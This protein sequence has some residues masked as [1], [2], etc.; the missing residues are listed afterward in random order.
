MLIENSKPKFSDFWISKVGYVSADEK[1]LLQKGD[2][3]FDEYGIAGQV[4]L[5]NKD[6]G[7]YIVF[8][9]GYSTYDTDIK[10][11]KIN[12]AGKSIYNYQKSHF[13]L[14]VSLARIM[15]ET[16]SEFYPFS[17][18]FTNGDVIWV[19]GSTMDGIVD[20]YTNKNFNPNTHS[21]FS[22]KLTPKYNCE[23]ETLILKK[24]L[25]KSW[26]NRE[27]LKSLFVDVDLKM[28]GDTR[29]KWKVTDNN[30]YNIDDWNYIIKKFKKY[31]IKY[32][33][34]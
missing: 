16:L 17:S 4:R 9:D 21:L 6:Y 5:T 31:Q 27:L 32:E 8:V 12:T 13:N 26:F 23:I 10:I 33:N 20:K 3:V 11:R 18:I 14:L 19:R 25:R 34:T 7:N 1:K 30:D 28:I 29:I 24:S 15:N 22:A 2:Y